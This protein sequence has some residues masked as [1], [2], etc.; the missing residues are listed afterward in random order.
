MAKEFNAEV[1]FSLQQPQEGISAKFD[2][3]VCHELAR[4]DSAAMATTLV[5]PASTPLTVP[6]Q[7]MIGAPQEVRKLGKSLAERQRCSKPAEFNVKPA[8][9]VKSNRMG[10]LGTEKRCLCVQLKRLG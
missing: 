5:A 9:P 4:R 1:V 10:G 6:V 3:T 8:I 2:K 7:Q